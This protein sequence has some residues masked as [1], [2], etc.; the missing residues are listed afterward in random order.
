V[1]PVLDLRSAADG[2]AGVERWR[3][4]GFVRLR[5]NAHEHAA[6]VTVD[7]DGF[8]PAVEPLQNAVSRHFERQSDR[9]ALER[10]GNAAAYRAAFQKLARLNKG[11]PDPH[12]LKVWL[13]HSHPPIAERLAMAEES[14][15]RMARRPTS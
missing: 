14:E 2:L 12:W 8:R 5:P 4:G 10:T 7:F 3:V 15:D 6:A 9:Y 11:D 1:R 13:F